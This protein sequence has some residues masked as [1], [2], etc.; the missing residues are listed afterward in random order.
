MDYTRVRV[1]RYYYIKFA[2]LWNLSFTNNFKMITSI[3]KEEV[4][5]MT[6][7]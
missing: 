5:C 7:S 1:K 6:Q 3:A 4:S 2:A